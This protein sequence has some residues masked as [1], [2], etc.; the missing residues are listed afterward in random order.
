M[1]LRSPCTAIAAASFFSLAGPGASGLRAAGQLHRDREAR[2]W[3]EALFGSSVEYGFSI[4][5]RHTKVV[6]DIPGRVQ[7]DVDK[8]LCCSWKLDASPVR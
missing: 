4:F 5:L 8:V 2:I 1:S 7:R 3:A 6:L